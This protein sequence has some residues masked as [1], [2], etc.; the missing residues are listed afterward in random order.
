MITIWSVKPIKILKKLPLDE[1]NCE[2]VIS[3]DEIYIITMEFY[4]K[5]IK[6]WKFDSG[7]L[8]KIICFMYVSLS[9]VSLVELIKSA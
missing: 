6:F 7:E 5:S 4:H 8:I 1:V 2:I 3:K 9:K